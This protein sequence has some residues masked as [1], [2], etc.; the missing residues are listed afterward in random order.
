MISFITTDLTSVG[1]LLPYVAKS[2]VT[3]DVHVNLCHISSN[4]K[5]CVN[6]LN[7]VP[8]V[9]LEVAVKFILFLLSKGTRSNVFLFD[10][11]IFCRAWVAK[12]RAR[13]HV[14]DVR[15]HVCVCVRKD[16]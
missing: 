3:S 4:C 12:V 7:F 8:F 10:I 6:E 5:G 11:A 14:C 1:Q 16:F 9:Y 15:S 13:T 2:V